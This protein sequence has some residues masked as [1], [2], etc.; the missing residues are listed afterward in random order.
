MARELDASDPVVLG[1]FLAMNG[2]LWLAF[3]I[4][5]IVRWHFIAHGFHGLFVG[6]A[7]IT[8]LLW[9]SLLK[10]KSSVSSMTGVSLLFMTVVM[11]SGHVL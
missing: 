9:H 4:R 2:V 5:T 6:L 1:I 8:P 11:L 10:D 3:C 7:F